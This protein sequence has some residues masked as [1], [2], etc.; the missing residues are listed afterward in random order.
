MSEVRDED[1]EDIVE[2]D[3]FNC[4]FCGVESEDPQTYPFCSSRCA[5]IA[6]AESEEDRWNH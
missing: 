2:R 6:R 4:L 1:D 5:A 3:S